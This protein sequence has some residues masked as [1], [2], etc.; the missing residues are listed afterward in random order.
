MASSDR[1]HLDY[2][3]CLLFEFKYSLPTPYINRESP[4]EKKYQTIKKGIRRTQFCFRRYRHIT[5]NR[6]PTST[7]YRICNFRLDLPFDSHLDDIFGLPRRFLRG[8][9]DV[10]SFKK[11]LI[12]KQ[13]QII[14]KTTDGR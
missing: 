4:F 1:E 2:S 14:T 12:Q 3:G 5:L 13:S 10:C 7:V 9:A 8:N 6:I 11:F